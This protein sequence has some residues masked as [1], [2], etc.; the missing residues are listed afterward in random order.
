[1]K[2]SFTLA[3]FLLIS[4]QFSA[5]SLRGRVVEAS[6]QQGIPFVTVQLGD[7]YGVISNAEGYFVLQRKTTSEE[8]PILFSSMGFESVEI[9]LKDFEENQIISLKP[10]TYELDEV[11]LFD[12]QL[13]AEEILEKFEAN[14]KEN[15]QLSNAKVQVFLRSN[16]DYKAE[17]FGIDIKKASYLSK[18]ERKEMNAN[19]EDLGNKIT[20]K[21][22]KSYRERLINIYALEDTLVNEYQKALN[23][24][25]RETTFDTEDIQEEV[26]FELMKS[27][28]SPYSF[29][30]KTG[31]IPID[32][33]VSLNELIE[34][35]ENDKLKLPDTVYHKNSW[36]SESY[37]NKA[38]R[39]NKDFLTSTKHYNYELMGVTKVYGEPCYHIK[40]S[41][42]PWRWKGK[43]V[44]NLYINTKD[45]GMVSYNYDLDEGEKTMNVNLKFVLGIKVN[46]F[47][48]SGFLIFTRN[49]DNTYYPKYIKQTDGSYAYISR[50]LSFKEN[51]PDRSQRKQLKLAFELEYNLMETT[52]YVGVEYQSI[53]P[54][55]F[56][57]LSFDEY[58]LIDEVE[59][60]DTNYWKDYNIIEATEAIKTYK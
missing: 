25:N 36:R 45:F 28:K 57:S 46:S 60:Y 10:A 50:S 47:V 23:L 53:S 29:K 39:F 18:S 12:K 40:F 13:T 4:I 2:S 33:D 54:D 49:N 38:T 43:Y 59:K 5:Q 37:K 6:N 20:S 14:A 48:D 11:L 19:M 8:T 34:D 22:S 9:L 30:V 7:N 26:F 32:K 42:N 1:M 27:L 55:L 15:H 52:E 16:D 31:I 44:G 35:I 51:N 41:P 17:T 3:L 24:I 58:I 21:S 56:N